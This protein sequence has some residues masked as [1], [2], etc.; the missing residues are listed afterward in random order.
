MGDKAPK[1]K[2]KKKKADD[3]K[4]AAKPAA[5]AKKK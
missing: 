2:D 1:D 4:G 5:P 3:K